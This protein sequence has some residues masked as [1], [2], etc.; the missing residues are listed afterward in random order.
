MS[1]DRDDE[2]VESPTL[3]DATALSLALNAAAHS[4]NVATAAATF[5]E[6]QTKLVRLQAVDL[7]REDKIRHR[8]LHVRHVNDLIKLAFE[9][10]AALIALT[11]AAGLAAMIWNAREATGLIIQP[12]NAP[13]DF[14]ARGLD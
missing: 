9:L 12:I 7:E 14:A 8:S 6:E 5:L 13:P 2:H 4:E 1:D 3:P 10:G 11:V